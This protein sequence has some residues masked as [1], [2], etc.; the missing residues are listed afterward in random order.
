MLAAVG[1]CGGLWG[2]IGVLSASCAWACGVTAEM[3]AEPGELSAVLREEGLG[4]GEVFWGKMD[5]R[6][7]EVG[8]GV[9]SGSDLGPRIMAC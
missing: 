3:G 6:P 8:G 5:E 1:V 4:I 9:C 2:V 7:V